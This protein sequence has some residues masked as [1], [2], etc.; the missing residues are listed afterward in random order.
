[1]K[2]GIYKL[3]HITLLV[4]NNSEKKRSRKQTTSRHLRILRRKFCDSV[5][6]QSA[7]V[8]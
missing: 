6:V 3:L 7:I 1:M 4:K 5:M 2:Q 8:F